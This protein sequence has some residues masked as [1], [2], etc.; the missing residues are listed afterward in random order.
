VHK[1]TLDS[2]GMKDKVKE[3]QEKIKLNKQL[4][5]LVRNIVEVSHVYAHNYLYFYTFYS[6]FY[7]L[8][9]FLTLTEWN[10]IVTHDLSEA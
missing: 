6:F 8:N 10:D 4:P 2:D 3:N 7:I 5:Y 1:T 9:P